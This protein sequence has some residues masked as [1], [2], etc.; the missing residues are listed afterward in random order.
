[1]IVIIITGTIIIVTNI[2]NCKKG[3]MRVKEF[4]RYFNSRR[5]KNVNDDK[6]TTLHKLQRIGQTK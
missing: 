1:M 5:R 3:N 2:G 4:E 6:I